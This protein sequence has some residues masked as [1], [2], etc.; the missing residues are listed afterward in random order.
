MSDVVEF[1]EQRPF[2]HWFCSCTSPTADAHPR[3][4]W[5]QETCD[6]CGD[7][8]DDLPVV[9]AIRNGNGHRRA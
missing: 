8:R 9:R 6:V 2:P 5:E 4:P 7:R 1:T 3:N